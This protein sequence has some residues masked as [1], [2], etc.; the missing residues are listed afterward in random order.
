MSQFHFSAGLLFRNTFCPA[1]MC[2]AAV[3]PLVAV[4]GELPRII[5][6][7]KCMPSSA[8]TTNM[9]PLMTVG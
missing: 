8:N 7:A 2:R 9:C 6:A 3:L 4:D 1:V 5:Q